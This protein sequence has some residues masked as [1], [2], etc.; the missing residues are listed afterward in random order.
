MRLW[1]VA[2]AVVRG[3]AVALVR[4]VARGDDVSVVRG[5]AFATTVAVPVADAVAV[6][7]PVAVAVAVAV[8]VPAPDSVFVAE[9]EGSRGV[10][11]LCALPPAPS[12]WEGEGSGVFAPESPEVLE[13]FGVFA[14][15][16]EVPEWPVVNSPVASGVGSLRAI[17]PVP[18]GRNHH[19]PMSSSSNSSRSAAQ[20]RRV[21]VGRGAGAGVL[22]T[23]PLRMRRGSRRGRTPRGGDPGRP[24]SC[25]HARGSGSAFRSGLRWSWRRI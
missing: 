9:G 13:G 25:A 7:A 6:P 5:V 20:R 10:V 4:G 18:A 19:R 8:A 21:R 15:E 17:I 24:A 1:G 12:R 3:V 2:V 23:A 14:P 11:S 16:V 22:R